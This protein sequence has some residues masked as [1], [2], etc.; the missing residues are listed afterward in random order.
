MI[1]PPKAVF[2]SYAS[3]DSD[4][5]RRICEALRAG[6][7]E[8]WFDQSEL[9]GG[10]VWDRKIRRQIRECALFVP[11][12]SANTQSRLEGYFRREWRLAVD[13]MYDMAAE[14]AFLVPVVIDD[15]NDRIAS[16]PEEFRAVQWTRLPAG[17][18]PPAFAERV[19][20][21]LSGDQAAQAT[22]IQ[23]TPMRAARMPG[24]PESAPDQA[25]ANRTSGDGPAVAKQRAKALWLIVP[26]VL[27]A[28][29]YLVLRFSTT[30]SNPP[31][32]AQAALSASGPPAADQIPEKSIAVL[33]FLN[34]SSDKEQEFFS[35]GLSEELIDLL[36]QVPDLRVPART[37]SFYFRG[38]ADDI[39]A[40]AHKLRVAHLLEGSVRKAGGRLRITAQLIRAD[41]GYHLW[42]ETYDRDAKD[43]FKVQDEIAAAVVSALKV[44]LLSAPDSSARQTQNPAAYSQYLLG[45]QILEQGDWNIAQRAVDAFRKALE[46]D[47]AYAP[48][49]AGLALALELGAQ[50]E[51]TSISDFDKNRH[52]AMEAAE[53][54]IAL[55]PDLAEGYVSR[56]FLRAWD[57][58]NFAG[59]AADYQ[60]ALALEPDNP[61][62]LTGFAGSVLVPTGRLD[63][64]IAALQKAL[65]SDPLN[66]GYWRSLAL[67]Q[68]ARGEC[69][70]AIE[71]ADRSLNLSP[72]QSNTAAFVGYCLLLEHKPEEALKV[73]RRATATPFRLQV[74]AMA[75]YD[76]RHQAESER[77]LK[78]LIEHFKTQA[79]YQIAQVYAMRGDITQ[80]FEWLDTAYSQQDG[81]L[82]MVK[83]DPLMAKLHGDPRFAALLRKMNLPE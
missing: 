77:L 33:P 73:S 42:S 74:A 24:M 76:L 72:G 11:I 70:A 21:L 61:K 57:T 43:V 9:R 59:A 81:G 80:A 20:R 67:A 31:P 79:A 10:D 60:R 50:E 29:G 56:G 71:N 45:R 55:A 51:S 17:D 49:W 26:L 35:D 46:L 28:I 65:Q 19:A 22:P 54:A 4:A 5:A 78:E 27:L 38:K 48:A 37:S 53:K 12:V 83:I 6:G 1:E 3:Q 58:R 44:R 40:I 41:S 7:I 62:V 75:E 34:M 18:T 23:A 14:K 15:T 68:W 82:T 47:P 66:S 13:R 2:L 32:A 36:S 25:A 39:A 8:V 64:A 52:A 16:V 69:P 30:T 63:E